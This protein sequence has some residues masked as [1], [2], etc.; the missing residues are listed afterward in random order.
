[1]ICR[2]LEEK[3]LEFAPVYRTRGLALIYFREFLI[4]FPY[5]LE[6]TREH[7][8]QS[9]SSSYTRSSTASSGSHRHAI[10]VR[11]WGRELREDFGTVS[12]SFVSSQAGSYRPDASLSRTPAEEQLYKLNERRCHIATFRTIEIARSF[13]RYRADYGWSLEDSGVWE[14]FFGECAKYLND[15]E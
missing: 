14:T 11:S 5:L 10:K 7:F 13:Q 12:P 15:D 3:Q 4:N 2:L 6:A 9:V 1:L 8:I